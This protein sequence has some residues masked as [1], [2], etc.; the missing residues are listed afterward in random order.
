MGF[1][2]PEAGSELLWLPLSGCSARRIPG[3]DERC[4]VHEKGIHVAAVPGAQLYILLWFPPAVDGWL[5]KTSYFRDS[6]SRS[7]AANCKW[8]DLNRGEEH[9]VPNCP[10]FS[11]SR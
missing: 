5:P 3:Q 6:N 2:N 10:V 8:R 7:E 1:L 4:S 9:G 11:T